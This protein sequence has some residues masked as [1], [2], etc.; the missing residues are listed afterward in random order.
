[1]A[2]FVPS[3]HV[4]ACCCQNVPGWRLIDYIRRQER[5]NVK[6]RKFPSWLWFTQSVT[7][8]QVPHNNGRE[9]L[10]IGIL[11]HDTRGLCSM[12]DLLF[13]S[14]C[15]E[16]KW[17]HPAGESWDSW[18]ELWLW[19]LFVSDLRLAGLLSHLRWYRSPAPFKNTSSRCS[20][21]IFARHFW[22]QETT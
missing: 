11:T 6:R 19:R 12:Q 20:K 4:L 15:P 2:D 9:Q 14:L 10:K 7:H 18:P 16:R 21:N 17:P 8:S 5:A 13:R 1:M 3:R 22:P